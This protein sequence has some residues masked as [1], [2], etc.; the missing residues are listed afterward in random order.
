MRAVFGGAHLY[1]AS[2]DRIRRTVAD[3]VRLGPELVALGHC[4]GAK[5][6]EVFAETLGARFRA[7]RAGARFDLDVAT[8][9]PDTA[10]GNSERKD[11]ER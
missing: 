4:T 7:L 10:D 9:D 3:V 2:T 6:E 11:I 8:T 5:A 1:A